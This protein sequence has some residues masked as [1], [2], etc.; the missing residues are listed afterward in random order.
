MLFLELTSKTNHF[1]VIWKKPILLRHFR[2]SYDHFNHN[3][4]YIAEM[5]SVFLK[6][7]KND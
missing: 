2:P 5:K 7:Q 4:A 3:W 1:S 6:L